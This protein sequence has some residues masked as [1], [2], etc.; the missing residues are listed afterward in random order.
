MP[1]CDAIAK[2]KNEC[3]KA[4]IDAKQKGKNTC[5]ITIYKSE[6]FTDS[7][8]YRRRAVCTTQDQMCLEETEEVFS[9]L[10]S[11]MVN[12]NTNGDFIITLDLHQTCFS[13]FITFISNNIYYYYYYLI[14]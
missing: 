14:I 6:Y 10:S 2:I 12:E 3:S 7:V 11:V 8:N 1:Q 9:N 5:Q 13:T 4:I